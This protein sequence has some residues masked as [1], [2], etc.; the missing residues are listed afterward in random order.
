MTAWISKHSRR[1]PNRH[2]SSDIKIDFMLFCA[3]QIFF[4][5]DYLYL[6]AIAILIN[7]KSMNKNNSI[8][9]SRLNI[10]LENR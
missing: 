5:I 9:I 10:K 3:I 4:E 7:I 8:K 2:V 6:M 1:T